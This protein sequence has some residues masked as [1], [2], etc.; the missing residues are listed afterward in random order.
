MNEKLVNGRKLRVNQS[1]NRLK[2]DKNQST[3][4]IEVKHV[5]YNNEGK[6][7]FI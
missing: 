6:C 4:N 3:K 7:L 5:A 1:D 2:Q